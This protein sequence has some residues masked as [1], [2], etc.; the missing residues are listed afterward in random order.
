VV[1]AIL[2][3]LVFAWMFGFQIYDIIQNKKKGQPLSDNVI[4]LVMLV[5]LL[6][7]TVVDYT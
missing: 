7:L 2:L 4:N 6:I 1:K 3:A 5:F